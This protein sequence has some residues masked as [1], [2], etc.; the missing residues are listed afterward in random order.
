MCRSFR[1]VKAHETHYVDLLEK[2][3][4]AARMSRVGVVVDKRI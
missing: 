3:P 1:P 4:A 2:I